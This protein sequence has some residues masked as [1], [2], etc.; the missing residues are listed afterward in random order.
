V[1]AR[2]PSS[3]PVKEALPTPV[4]VREGLV[5][6]WTRFWFQPADPVGLHVI[7]LLAG[8][9]FLAWLL[10]F[11]GHV[12]ELFGLEGWFDQQAYT[13]AAQLPDFAMQPLGWSILYPIGSNQALLTSVYWASLGVLL[14]FTLGIWTRLTGVLT[15]LIVASFTTNPAVSYDGDALLIIL[16]FYLMIGYLLLGQRS[17]GLSAAAR[18]LGST[19]SLLLGRQ[20]GRPQPSTGANLALRL[21]QVHFAI[22][23]LTSGLHKT[24]FGDWWAGVALWY[25]LNM[26]FETSLEQAR[27]VSG[28]PQVYLAILSTAAYVALAWQITFPLFAWRPRWW[29]V[30]VGGAAVSWAAMILIY[31]LPLLGPALFIGCLSFVS[32]AGWHRLLDW[33]ARR[34]PARLIRRDETAGSRDQTQSAVALGHRS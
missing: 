32:A 24:Q 10:P 11:A 1:N 28:D 30:L 29:P 5:A 27:S 26:P 19:E 3:V 22:V 8:V 34:L 12:H 16:S 17:G 23:V 14:L 7:R 31:R 21:L 33:L 20:R 6:A 25:P 4:P 18:L 15:W 13:E 2:R 9:L